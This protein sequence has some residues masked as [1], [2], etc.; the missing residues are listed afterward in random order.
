VAPCPDDTLQVSVQRE[1][2]EIHHRVTENSEKK[3][4]NHEDPKTQEELSA[5][6]TDGP[7]SKAQER[8][9]MSF[10]I[11]VNLYNLWM[12]FLFLCLLCLRGERLPLQIP[13][14]CRFR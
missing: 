13:N 11:C 3:K 14:L 4:S 12:D 1:K 5:D 2:S 7:D 9:F 10:L 8:Y 6:S